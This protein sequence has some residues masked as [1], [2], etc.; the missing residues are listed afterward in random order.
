MS[1]HFSPL[2]PAADA[3]TVDGNPIASNATG[4]RRSFRAVAVGSAVMV[5]GTLAMTTLIGIAAITGMLAAGSR[6]ES[7]VTQLP[8]SIALALFCAG[9]GL[10]MNV[11]GG[12]YAAVIAGQRPLRHALWSG[13]LAIPFNLLILVVLGD[14]GPAWLTGLATALIVPCAALG[15]WL[16]APASTTAAIIAPQR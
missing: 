4:L 15:G 11:I 9:G 7:I 14:S 5:G 3:T 12:Y 1:Q 8:D 6:A 16:A 13:A 10:L 2:F